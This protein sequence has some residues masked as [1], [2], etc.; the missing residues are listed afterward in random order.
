M[1]DNLAEQIRRWAV[2]V[3][4]E[5]VTPLMVERLGKFSAVALESEKETDVFTYIY[6][7]DGAKVAG[8]LVA[9][10]NRNKKLPVIIF[11]RG[12]TAD[13]GLVPKGRLFTRFAHLASWGYII[14]GTQYPGN[15]LSEGSDER[16]GPSDV[17]SVLR[18]YDLIKLLDGAD[19]N[20]IGMYGESRGGMMTYLCMKQV[21]WIKVALT[22]GG[23]ANLERSLEY[24][25]EMVE[26]YEKHFGN[27]TEAKNARSVV[28]WADK[29]NKTTPLCLL[30]GAA[31]DKVNIRDA[32]ELA[33]KLD[34]T[35]HPFSLHILNDGDHGLM[36]VHKERDGL[37]QNWFE[38][39]LKGEQS[40]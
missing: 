21:A 26:V 23:L 14:I 5:S 6:E 35:H 18:L 10:K 25:P 22:V 1:K 33:K 19:E 12:G 32:L 39:Y 2:A 29:L 11:N 20:N 24:R 31:D 36:N 15:A 13:Y 28:K 7:S 37:I 8:F 40:E 34:E 9:P 3:S 4:Q 30:H 17:N 27:T 16:G 38:R